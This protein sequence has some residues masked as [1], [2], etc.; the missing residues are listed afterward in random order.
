MREIAQGVHF[1]MAV[2]PEASDGRT[3]QK[4]GTSRNDFYGRSRN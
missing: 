3:I 4:R 2:A 1:Y